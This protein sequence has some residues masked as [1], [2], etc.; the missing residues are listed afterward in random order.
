MNG[1]VVRVVALLR[2]RLGDKPNVVVLRI[3]I[4]SD[5]SFRIHCNDVTE[6]LRELV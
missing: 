2:N 6:V 4:V 5:H 1:K 3:E